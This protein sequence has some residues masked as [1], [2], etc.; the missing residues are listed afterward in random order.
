MV[1]LMCTPHPALPAVRRKLLT[2]HSL[3]RAT[4]LTNST[5]SD[6]PLPDALNPSVHTSLP[7]RLTTLF[8]LLRDS[9]ASLIRLPFFILPLLVHLPAY[10]IARI[11]AKIV[12]DQEETQAQNKVVYA[13]LLLSAVYPAIFFFLWKF[14]WM[15]PLGAI[16]ALATSYAFV[17]YHTRIIDSNYAQ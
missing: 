6:L 17:V 11:G 7:S 13:L 14:F 10:V 12:E 4:N 2:Y 3:L 8:V 9:L 1:D 15:T 5:L 16:I